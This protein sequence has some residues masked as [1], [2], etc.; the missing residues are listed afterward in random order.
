VNGRTRW[1]CPWE[2]PG[3]PSCLA[4]FLDRIKGW[5]IGSKG[6]E[7]HRVKSKKLVDCSPKSTSCLQSNILEKPLM[8]I[9]T[10]EGFQ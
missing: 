7:E 1:I 5:T 4:A 2:C 10:I 9:Q 3:W 6:K 8:W